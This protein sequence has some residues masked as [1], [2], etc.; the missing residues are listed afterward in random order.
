MILSPVARNNGAYVVHQT[1]AR[2]LA[3]Y[4]V[5]GY[6]P[7]RTLFPPSLWPLGRR[8]T[9]DLIHTTPDYAIFHQRR[10]VPLVITFHGY[11]LDDFMRA[12]SGW[13][14]RLHYATDLA[15]FTRLAVNKATAITAVSH[16]T[17]H[18]V[19]QH[20]R[21]IQPVTVIYNGVDTDKFQPQPRHSPY[22]H[23]LFSGN[24]KPSKGAHWLPAIAQRLSPQIRLYYTCG[25]A[26]KKP[27]PMA[28]NLLPIAPVAHDDMPA[29]YQNA[30]ILLFPTVREGFGLAA[31]EAMACGLPVVASDCSALPELID[32]GRGGFLCP[33]GDVVCFAKKINQLADDARLRA[34][35]GAYNRA[36][37]E[38]QFTLARM[39]AGY[40][41]LF[42]SLI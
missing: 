8:Q 22:I 41:Q 29:L 27:L 14:Q 15:W 1:L 10:D 33:V 42:A 9:V 3:D 39:L 16:F 12:Y 24:L 37:V 5:I 4:R 20:L 35:M 13:A 28:D 17:A 31:A 25:L 2:H 26:A 19:Q 32:H 23:V 40:Q 38:R 6:H 18:W 30:D 21:L 11:V 34:S 7:Y 36:K